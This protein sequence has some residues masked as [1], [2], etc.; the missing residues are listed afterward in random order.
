MIRNDLRNNINKKYERKFT[1]DQLALA[2]QYLD[3]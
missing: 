2:L 1:I 3:C